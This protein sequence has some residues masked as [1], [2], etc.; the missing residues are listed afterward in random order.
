M[1]SSKKRYKLKSKVIIILSCILC[2]V[3]GVL[4][5]HYIPKKSNIDNQ[6]NYQL[7]SE[8]MSII[9]DNWVNP[10]DNDTNDNDT[11][12]IKSFVSSLGDKYTSYLTSDEAKSLS[13]SINGSYEGL[14]ISFSEC[15]LGALVNQVYNNTSAQSAGIKPGDIITTING[16]SI[17]ELSIT[18]IQ[19]II[20]DGNTNKI[21]LKIL[22]N[23]SIINK[24]LV[25]KSFESDVEYYVKDNY[26]Y[27]KLNTFGEDSASRVED[28]LIAFK[29]KNINNIIIDVRDN[30][31]GYLN[32]VWDILSL[33]VSEGQ[34]IFKTVTKSKTTEYKAKNSN[35][36]T[37]N[38]G[39][40][41]MNEESA[42]CSEVLIGALTEILNYS[43]IG[44]NS[45]GKGIAQ[46][47]KV[48]SNNDILKYTYARWT[49]PSGSDIQGKGFKPNIEINEENVDDYKLSKFKGNF[50]VDSVS[51][52]VK[53]AQK[54][55]KRLGYKVDRVDG[56]F[57]KS[58]ETALKQYQAKIKVKQDGILNYSIASKLYSSIT[59]TLLQTSTDKCLNKAIELCK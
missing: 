46:D 42:S 40:I 50:K 19:S 47:Q 43:T 52:Y 32:A 37:F 5:G 36:Y 8:I 41:L 48:L 28:A 16:K 57:S 27:L 54:S 39:Y 29:D 53:V 6:H 51:D 35:K 15:T 56:Y 34:V 45:F 1:D 20:L 18:K 44:S 33:F 58:T 49:T 3:V 21:S 10:N 31:G 59:Y 12:M 22:R 55:L 14:G 11:T 24:K 17:A 38:K 13:D 4:I 30:G 26:G 23:A 7:L 25:K 2:L 9:D